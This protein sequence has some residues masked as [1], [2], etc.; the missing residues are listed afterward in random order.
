MAIDREVTFRYD[1]ASLGAA[2]QAVNFKPPS[3]TS[4]TSLMTISS[5][6]KLFH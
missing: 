3:S 1:C 5:T 4:K 2:V 6:F